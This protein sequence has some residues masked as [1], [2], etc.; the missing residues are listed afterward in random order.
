MNAFA[1]DQSTHTDFFQ[2]NTVDGKA[3]NQLQLKSIA[4]EIDSAS[5]I[6]IRR[7]TDIQNTRSLLFDLLFS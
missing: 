3:T 1:T 5:R 4:N 6:R 2:I 7:L